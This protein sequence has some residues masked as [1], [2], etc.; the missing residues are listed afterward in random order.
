MTNKCNVEECEYNS[1]GVCNYC[2]DYFTLN[3]KNKCIS[4]EEE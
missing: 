2:G 1:E 3:N 4:F